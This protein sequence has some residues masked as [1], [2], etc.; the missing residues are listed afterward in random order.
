[1]SEVSQR[2]RQRLEGSG[3]GPW[4]GI[5][6]PVEVGAGQPE[7]LA[8]A[9]ARGWRPTRAAPVHGTRGWVWWPRYRSEVQAWAAGAGHAAKVL[10]LSGDE[11]LLD[12]GEWAA[13]LGDSDWGRVTFAQS[14]G[15]PAALDPVRGLAGRAAGDWA[16]HPQL[17]AALAPL[18]PDVEQD[19][20]AQ[21]AR[22]P[23]VTP[24][25]QALLGV[26]GAALATLADGGWLWP[27][28]GGWR[29]P[30]LLRR[31]L[32]PAPDV[33]LSAQV[34]AALSSAGHVG[35][36]LDALREAQ[37]WE[38]Y[39]DLLAQESRV[40]TGAD[41]LREA[42]HPVPPHWRE[43][44]AGLYLAGL[45]ARASRDPER[46]GALYTRALPGLS[47]ATRPLALNARGVVRALQ[48]QPDSALEDFAE[49]A[50]TGGLIGGEAEHNRATLL[51]QLGRHAEAEV[52]LAH[53]VAAFRGA[54][55]LRREVRSLETLGNLQFGRGLLQEAQGPYIQV[56]HLLAQAPPQDTALT[57]INLA[58]TY[59]LLG[60][61]AQARAELQ[62]AQV[63]ILAADDLSGWA[64]RIHALLFLQAGQPT[65]ARRLLEGIGEANP[66]L[67]AEA[68][69]LLARA[70]RELGD[71]EAAG[72]A[73][74]AA[75]S[76]GLRAALEEALQGMAPLDEVVEASRREDARL[77]LATALLYRAAPTD[78]TAAL[79]LIHTHGYRP[80]LDSPAAHHLLGVLRDDA[81]RAL[82]PLRLQ[83][84]GPLRLSHAGRTWGAG[85][86]PARKSAAL[87]VALALSGR[88]L[89][90]EQLAE[91]FWPD[92]KNPLASLQTAIY[93]LRST[94][95]VNLVS[96]ARGRLTLAFAVHSDLRELQVALK[97][98][99]PERL[100]ELLGRAGVPA[101][102]TDLA[103][104]LGEEAEYASRLIHDAL[105]VHAEVQ[106][107][108]SLA[109]RDALRALISADPLHLEARAQLAD[110]HMHQ[111]DPESA[112]QERWRLESLQAEL[113]PLT[114]E[115]GET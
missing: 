86:L 52:A 7:L 6:A 59:A 89:P 64:T 8:W 54:G 70:C 48:G 99:D 16:A 73:L 14:S 115:G 96:S 65:E 5:V 10:I 31:L 80:L 108:Q 75:R 84:L 4:A 28:P 105:Q 43:Q 30:A 35:E 93:H 12:A 42:L 38:A 95:G 32:V 103:A 51:I 88:S 87:L 106:P 94:F 111:G 34:A 49:A 41:A 26:D 3:N 45:L 50:Q 11:L 27:A 104:E 46:A 67:H 97:T 13:A 63:D 61:T 113:E 71:V 69:L 107:P 83:V 81:D 18:L 29:V 53:A 100:A 68:A 57:H 110:W 15:W 22:T 90:R 37:L 55:D 36:A 102:L 74:N 58:E 109:R 79:D 40:G 112:Q 85:D 9:Q 78:L 77:E 98:R 17:Q 24:P 114:R 66:T 56:L 101:V 60:E 33:T 92:A 82:L 2:L 76:L 1:M 21:L 25:V 20:Y 39:L 62:R 72:R 47:S 23:L 19:N 91:R 44:P